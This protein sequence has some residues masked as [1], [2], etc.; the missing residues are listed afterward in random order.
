MTTSGS[1]GYFTTTL[2]VG[3]KA[4]LTPVLGARIEARGLASGVGDPP[5]G[6]ACSEFTTPE[7]PGGP[8]VP[9]SCAH[10]W[11]LTGDLTAGIVVAF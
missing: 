9:V 5:L 1:K 7:G 4:F 11:I 8:I 6:F 2:A 3:L 10:Q